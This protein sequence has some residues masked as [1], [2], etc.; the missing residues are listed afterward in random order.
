MD[1]HETSEQRSVR[2]MASEKFRPSVRETEAQVELVDETRESY[3]AEPK[4]ERFA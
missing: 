1:E 4:D 3:E 2:A